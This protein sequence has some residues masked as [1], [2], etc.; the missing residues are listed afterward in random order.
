MSRI[1]WPA[2]ET[3]SF[4]AGLGGV[5]P[6]LPAI[7]KN[8]DQDSSDSN[9]VT[10]SGDPRAGAYPACSLSSSMRLRGAR[11]CAPLRFQILSPSGSVSAYLLFL[12][13]TLGR[14]LAFGEKKFVGAGPT[15]NLARKQKPTRTAPFW[16]DS[17]SS[18]AYP[19]KIFFKV[20]DFLSEITPKNFSGTPWGVPPP[21]R[22]NARGN[23]TFFLWPSFRA[24]AYQYNDTDGAGTCDKKITS[25]D[26][27]LN[28]AMRPALNEVARA[29][30]A[31]TSGLTCPTVLF[32]HGTPLNLP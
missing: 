14:T 31:P 28:V 7:S 5:L 30:P 29:R 11:P 17:A 4:L 19:A 24:V 1:G 27:L 13:A 25:R 15:Q 21:R 12:S 20:G 9:V 16:T 6:T 18:P 22:T 23:R 3:R 32:D 2:A 26:E 8:F 10:G